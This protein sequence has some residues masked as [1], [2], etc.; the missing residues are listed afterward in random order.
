MYNIE[1]FKDMGLNELIDMLASLIS[2]LEG[3]TVSEARSMAK[4]VAR[5]AII[6]E[7][8]W[9]DNILDK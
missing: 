7:I 5:R 4:G 6:E 2:E 3:V 9:V 8:Q 1:V